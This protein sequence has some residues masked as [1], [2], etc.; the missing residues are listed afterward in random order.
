M[1]DNST[2]R[3][4]HQRKRQ[5][6]LS[7]GSGEAPSQSAKSRI[8]AFMQLDQLKWAFPNI[9]LGGTTRT[10][11]RPTNVNDLWKVLRDNK[12]LAGFV[13]DLPDILSSLEPEE[14]GDKAIRT[15]V[16]RPEDA[17][18]STHALGIWRGV[19]NAFIGDPDEYNLYPLIRQILLWP[20][21]GPILPDFPCLEV[22]E[23]QGLLFN[24]ASVPK[25]SKT[26]DERTDTGDQ[27]SDV[28]LCQ[29]L[30]LGS[31]HPLLGQTYERLMDL[32]NRLNVSPIISP[33]ESQPLQC[34]FVG[35]LV[36]VRHGS[37]EDTRKVLSQIALAASAVLE[38]EKRVRVSCDCDRICACREGWEIEEMI[39]LP[40][41]TIERRTWEMQIAYWET[42]DQIRV[43]RP[44]Y[45]GEMSTF[46]GVCRLMCLMDSIKS[47]V[48]AKK[49]PFLVRSMEFLASKFEALI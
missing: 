43:T 20:H 2:P 11:P 28:K 9:L 29:V 47:W 18:F 15:G 7:T 40:C 44:I 23:A 37:D 22:I 6:R 8:P 25:P 41:F 3:T 39:P 26:S 4:P 36:V 13:P 45:A 10:K 12:E 19:N 27:I 49:V 30:V 24:T 42:K 1:G 17:Q 21:S 33:F 34:R 38:A 5:R 46:E 35:V 31:D 16:A 14:I 48:E 32:C